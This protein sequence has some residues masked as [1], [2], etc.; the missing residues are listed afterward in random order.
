MPRY[1]SLQIRD[2]KVLSENVQSV[3]SDYSVYN[4]KNQSSEELSNDIRLNWDGSIDFDEYEQDIRLVYNLEAFVQ[5]VYFWLITSVGELPHN[6]FF[7]WD[8][9]KYIGETGK[10]NT[11]EVLKEIRKLETL[12][13]VEYVDNIVVEEIE[14]DATRYLSIGID[15][16]PKFF[17]YR[18]FMNLIFS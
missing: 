12:E 17:K 1:S 8:F 9:K 5:R 3:F 14:E 16:K 18:I 15:L 6:E 10:I 13:D 7:G 11:N 2:V 4:F